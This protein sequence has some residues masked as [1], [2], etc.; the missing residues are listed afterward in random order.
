MP[1]IDF[2]QSEAINA[3]LF[4]KRRPFPWIS[5]EHF[6][7]DEGYGRLRQSLPDVALCAQEFGRKRGHRQASHDRYALQY[8][9]GLPISAAWRDFIAE[10]QGEAYG[11]FLHRLYGL[12]R[13]ERVVLTMHWH[14]APQGASVSP[15]TDARRKIGSHIFYF[16]TAEDWDPAWGGQTLVLDDGGQFTAHSAHDFDEFREAAA[17]P[18]IGNNSFLFQRTEHSWHAVRPVACPPGR[19]RKVFIV[20]IN[21]MSWQ[22]RWRRLRGKD[23]DGYPLAG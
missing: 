1:Y 4:Q 19:L 20:V 2:A 9:P 10:L 6:L 5:V 3:E 15:H 18:V 7:T 11:S 13:R 16:N 12:S 17:S 14:Y 23:A 21:R 22:V 8:R